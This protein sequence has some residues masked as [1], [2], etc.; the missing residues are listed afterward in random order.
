MFYSVS[1]NYKPFR[2]AIETREKFP[3]PEELKIMLFQSRKRMSAEE[4][5]INHARLETE[6]GKKIKCAH[7]CE[8]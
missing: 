1:E 2:I 8:K 6:Q 4:D 7:L 5:Y 3:M